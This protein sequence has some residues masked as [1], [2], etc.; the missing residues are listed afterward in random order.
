MFT[1]DGFSLK[2]GFTKFCVH[3]TILFSYVTYVSVLEVE[4]LYNLLDEVDMVSSMSHK[5]F[6]SI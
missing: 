5:R 2:S 6:I 1:G 3:Q 4:Y